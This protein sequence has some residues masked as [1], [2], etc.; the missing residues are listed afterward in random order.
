MNDNQERKSAKQEETESAEKSIPSSIK[1]TAPEY[2]FIPKSNNWFWSVGI[3]AGGIA[4]ASILLGNFLFAI[5]V[6]IAGFAVII[7]GAKKPRKVEFSV[8]PRGLQIDKRLFPFENLRS[9]WVH[10]DP[11]YK[12]LVSVEPKKFFMPTISAPLGDTNPNDIRKY[13]IKFIKEERQ[14]ESIITTI[15]RLLGF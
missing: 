6:L 4:F 11:P 8:G 15:S 10:Y 14:E 13:L 5:F 2:E 9:F 3:I 12:K 1:W 7:H